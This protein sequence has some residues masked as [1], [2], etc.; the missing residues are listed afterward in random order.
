[1]VLG[2]QKTVMAGMCQEDKDF[3]LPWMRY[4]LVEVQEL[5]RGGAEFYDG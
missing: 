5:Y 4:E 3:Y 1:L 2:G